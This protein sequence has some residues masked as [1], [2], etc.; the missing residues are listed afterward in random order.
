MV[1]TPTRGMTAVL[2]AGA[3]TAAVLGAPQVGA[4]GAPTPDDSGADITPVSMSSDSFTADQADPLRPLRQAEP[5]PEAI[6][7][8]PASTPAPKPTSTSAPKKSSSSS[9]APK[10]SSASTSK[11]KVSSGSPRDV[12]H[13]LMLRYGYGESQWQCLDAL[14]TRE[15]GWSVTDTNHSSGAYG[16]PQALPGSKMASAGSDWR[17]DPAT[18]ISWGLHYI[19]SRYGTPC[20]AWQ[21]SQHYNYY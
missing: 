11:P 19:D 3:F 13:R 4:A 16:I 20:A 17:T 14:W 7:R 12:G 18:Q 6:G 5:A 10:A 2:T 8:A 15:S 9:P 21:H 1:S